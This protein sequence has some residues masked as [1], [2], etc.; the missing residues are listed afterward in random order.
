MSYLRR[1]EWKRKSRLSL[2]SNLT[3]DVS[4]ATESLRADACGFILPPPQLQV[5]GRESALQASWNTC[6]R[7]GGEMQRGR[8]HFSRKG[9]GFLRSLPS[10]VT[11]IDKEENGG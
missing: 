9:S 2:N 11:L 10:S 6:E 3:K 5:Q 1:D 7:A 8:M 4:R